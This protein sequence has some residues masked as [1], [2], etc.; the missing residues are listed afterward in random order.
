MEE[1]WKDVVG[2][3]GYEVSNL[4]QVR[5]SNYNHTGKPKLLKQQLIAQGYLRVV[6]WINK[7]PYT[8]MVH[9]LVAEAFIPN[10]DNLPQVNHKDE[11]K[12]RNVAD[13]LEWCTALYNSQY[14]TRSQRLSLALTD[15][16]NFIKPVYQLDDF[17]NIINEYPSIAKAAEAMGCRP[18]YISRVC[19][20]YGY[21]HKALG[22]KWRFKN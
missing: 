15:N 1:Q 16:P 11:N 20:N 6:L 10:P 4:G 21:R 14:G 2:C 17:D 7:K 9:R 12:T 19:L 18:A 13:N 5:S 22:Y 8:K 3:P